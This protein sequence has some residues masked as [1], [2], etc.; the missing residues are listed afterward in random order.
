MTIS[1]TIKTFNR[2]K[3][4]ITSKTK[5][6]PEKTCYQ[7]TLTHTQTQHYPVCNETLRIPTLEGN[8]SRIMLG[9]HARVL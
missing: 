9:T 1:N 5:I 4:Q 3:I 6:I 7:N 2:N 8:V